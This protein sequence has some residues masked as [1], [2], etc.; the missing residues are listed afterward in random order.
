ML[1]LLLTRQ[2]DVE[3]FDN[4]RLDFLVFDEAHIRGARKVPKRRV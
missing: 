1:E 4:A 3:L 2:K